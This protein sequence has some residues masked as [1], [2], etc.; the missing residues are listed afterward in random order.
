M[1]S[2]SYMVVRNTTEGMEDQVAVFF[3]PNGKDKNHIRRIEKISTFK[4][5]GMIASD[6]PR[7]DRIT[8][9][10][11]YKRTGVDVRGLRL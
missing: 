8:E 10:I 6:Y 5:V 11:L 3:A 9:A 1:P 7:L 2:E 4:F